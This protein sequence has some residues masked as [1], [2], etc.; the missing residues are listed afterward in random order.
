MDTNN[1]K[2]CRLC[3]LFESPAL[4]VLFQTDHCKDQQPGQ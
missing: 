1:G 4:E 2:L 3:L